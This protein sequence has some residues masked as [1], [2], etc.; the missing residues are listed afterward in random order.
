MRKVE[1]WQT[2]VTKPT[3]A[4]IDLAAGAVNLKPLGTPSP[5]FLPH[6]G[7]HPVSSPF[8]ISQGQGGAAE[9]RVRQMGGAYE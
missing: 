7:Q 6:S 3:T 5:H 8:R 1:G 9:A 2:L 4:V